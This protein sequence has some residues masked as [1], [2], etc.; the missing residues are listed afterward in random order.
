MSLPRK[1][2]RKKAVKGNESDEKKNSLKPVACS[3]HHTDRHHRNHAR[4]PTHARCKKQSPRYLRLQ[5][6]RIYTC[7]HPSIIYTT[8][9]RTTLHASRRR[10]NRCVVREQHARGHCA[11]S[12]DCVHATWDGAKCDRLQIVE[13][14]S[15]EVFTSRQ[16][17]HAG[18]MQDRRHDKI[19][20]T[21]LIKI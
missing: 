11:V 5:I 9:A 18:I 4:L 14:H 2:T 21:D 20:H 10:C 8:T 15:G 16:V 12:N 1:E 3:D 13:V 6:T 19:S 17:G 7:A